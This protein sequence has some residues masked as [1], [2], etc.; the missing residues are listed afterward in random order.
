MSKIVAV[1][2]IMQVEDNVD[3]EVVAITVEDTLYNASVYDWE[4]LEAYVESEVVVG[5]EDK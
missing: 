5:T 2:V 3:A 4:L 1:T